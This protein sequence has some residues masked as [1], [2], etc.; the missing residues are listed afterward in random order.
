MRSLRQSFH[1]SDLSAPLDPCGTKGDRSRN[2]AALL[3][4][5][6]PQG[7]NGSRTLIPYDKREAL[8]LQQAAGIAGR[9]AETIRRWCEAEEIGRRV[10]GRWAVS[11]PALLMWLDGDEAALR[12]Y[13]AGDR[14]DGV[15]A[16]YFA[17]A[18][19]E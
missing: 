8:T 1:L 6:S 10:G 17:R 16:S 12:A 5:A 3:G 7:R 11:H 14:S 13:R 15:V 2:D 4:T 9:S 19:M 18:G